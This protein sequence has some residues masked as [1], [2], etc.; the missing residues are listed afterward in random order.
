MGLTKGIKEPLLACKYLLVMDARTHIHAF[1][2][3]LSLL[4]SRQQRSAVLVGQMI[5]VASAKAAAVEQKCA[6]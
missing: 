1:L 4:A 3:R 6:A 2:P 5:A